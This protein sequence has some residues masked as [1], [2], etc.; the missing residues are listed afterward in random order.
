MVTA[1][2]GND[3]A[4][5]IVVDFMVCVGDLSVVEA[6]CGAEAPVVRVWVCG[7]VVSI[8][9]WCSSRAVL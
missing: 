7:V 1:A 9:E 6:V 4:W 2:G 8:D 5:W 3:V